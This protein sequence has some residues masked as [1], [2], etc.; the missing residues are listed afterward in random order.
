MFEDKEYPNI[1]TNFVLNISERKNSLYFQIFL[2]INYSNQYPNCFI[3]FEKNVFLQIVI[4][5][6]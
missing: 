4:Q 1:K 5:K 2:K 6:F 3:A